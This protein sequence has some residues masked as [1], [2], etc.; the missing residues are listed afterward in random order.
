M[1]SDMH[2]ARTL[3]SSRMDDVRALK[4]I[5]SDTKA[6]ISNQRREKILESLSNSNWAK[7]QA[8]HYHQQLLRNYK[9]IP[10][11]LNSGLRGDTAKLQSKL[12]HQSYADVI[13]EKCQQQ[14]RLSRHQ[15]KRK[16]SNDV[17]TALYSM[18]SQT[19][20]FGLRQKITSQNHR[21]RN[22]L[23]TNEGETDDSKQ[24][25]RETD[26]FEI[27]EPFLKDCSDPYMAKIVKYSQESQKQQKYTP[28]KVNPMFRPVDTPQDEYHDQVT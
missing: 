5:I 8:S 10:K 21:I 3:I 15:K 12:Q 22:I 19:A 2:K 13:V 28:L 20:A 14:S 23:A 1:Q 9:G 26:S 27:D 25:K 17:N 16:S 7:T 6:T 18:R 4:K 11:T 24:E